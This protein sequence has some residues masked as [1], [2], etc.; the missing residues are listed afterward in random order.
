MPLK[1]PL[2]PLPTPPGNS[3]LLKAALDNFVAEVQI[4]DDE[5]T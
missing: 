2:V 5:G 1:Y 3:K 4:L